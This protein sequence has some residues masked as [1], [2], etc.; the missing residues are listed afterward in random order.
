M[1]VEKEIVNSYLM[2][3]QHLLPGTRS[4]SPLEVLKDLVV[5]DSNNLPNSYFCMALRVNNFYIPAFEKALFLSNTMARIWGLKNVLQII[6]RDMLSAVYSVTKRDRDIKAKKTLENWGVDGAEYETV[7]KAIVK[8]LGNK[9]KTLPQLKNSIAPGVSREILRK[10][11]RKKQESSTN[12]AIVASAMW[13]RWELIRG[14]IGRGEA[15]DPGRYSL[16]GNRFKGLDLDISRDIALETLIKGYVSRYGPVSEED[17]AWWCGI[18]RSEASAVLSRI[19]SLDIIE[20]SGVEGEFFI[21]SSAKPAIGRSKPLKQMIA[22]LPM[23]D[24]YIKA[25]FNTDRF[26]P[27]EHEDKVD[28]KFGSTN[29]AVLIDGAMWGT[30]SIKREKWGNVCYVEMFENHPRP[31]NLE[32]ELRKAALSAG[33]FL[34]GEPVEVSLGL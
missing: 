13:D 29:N 27:H 32:E 22:L 33:E 7:R 21:D 30:W 26:V 20:V 4:N 31:D 28:T 16:F 24:P 1:I 2:G 12:V 23:D 6:P 25:Y 14:G 18:T 19:G 15:E 9:E 17:V 3:R 10:K 34:T 8:A 5:L 11:S